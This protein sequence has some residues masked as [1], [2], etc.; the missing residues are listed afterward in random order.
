[1]EH[2]MRNKADAA[3]GV[4]CMEGAMDTFVT[5]IVPRCEI[6]GDYRFAG[7]LQVP[8]FGSM[9]I[10]GGAGEG[11]ERS[12][13][14]TRPVVMSATIQLDFEQPVGP[15]AGQVMGDL[16]RFRSKELVGGDLLKSSAAAFQMP[17]HP[18]AQT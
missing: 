15:G 13:R 1:M 17:A 3:L 7:G 11:G 8:P 9:M 12:I 18:R 10:S 6:E 2:P 4:T 14:R 16:C 5:P